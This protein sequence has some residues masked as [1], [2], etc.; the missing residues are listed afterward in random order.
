VHAHAVDRGT[1]R[2][3]QVLHIVGKCVGDGS[4]SGVRA[5]APVLDHLV[6]RRVDDIE[7]VAQPAAQRV[8]PG[9]AVEGVVVLVTRELV[10][11]KP[12]EALIQ[13][14]TRTT[15]SFLFKPPAD[16]WTYAMR[17]GC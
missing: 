16:Y 13:T 17:E 1:T 7:I 3:H 5:F 9:T 4:L 15:V 8:I 10:P 11:G 2:Q 12:V 14:D 6:A